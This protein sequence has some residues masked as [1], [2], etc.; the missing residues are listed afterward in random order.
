M[1]MPK[2]FSHPSPT[3]LLWDGYSMLT[4]SRP[5]IS[6]AVSVVAQFSTSPQRQHYQVVTPIF[7]YIAGTMQVH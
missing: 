5:D 3:P 2:H 7:C 4:L 6:Y 1:T